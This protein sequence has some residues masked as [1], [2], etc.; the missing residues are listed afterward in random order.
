MPPR[1]QYRVT[2]FDP[3]NRNEVG[4]YTT[5]EW[6]LHSQIGDTFDGVLLTEDEYLRVEDAY[7][8]TAMRFHVDAGQPDIFAIS[9]E[10]NRKLGAPAEGCLITANQLPGLCRAMLREDY[11]CRIE[12]CG[13]FIHF[14]YDF[15]MYIGTCDASE[16]TLVFAQSQGLFPEPFVSPY[17]PE[18]D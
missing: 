13:F 1:H 18:H 4:H 9:V 17:H 5:D 8:A 3:A 2:K 14:G 6:Y 15:Y 16:H 7:I 11:W 12:G 10:D